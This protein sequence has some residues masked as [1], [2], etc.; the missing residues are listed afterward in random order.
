MKN[1]IGFICVLGAFT[2]PALAAMDVRTP[3]SGN[4]AATPTS[5]AA[6]AP[7]LPRLTAA[8]I[9]D[10]NVAARG[11][12]EAWRHVHSMQMSGLMDL[13]HA[14]KR[15]VPVAMTREQRFERSH[16]KYKDEQKEAG[17]LVQA[18]FLMELERPTKVRV[19]LQFAGQ[20]AVQVYDGEHG[21]KLRP[22]L[23]RKEP[24]P[25]TSDEL[26]AAAQQQELDGPLIDYA[27]KG[28]KI[29]LAGTDE[30]DGHSTYKLKVMLRSG[31]TRYVWIDGTSFLDVKIDGVPRRMDGKLRSVQTYMRDYRSVD[32]LMIPHLIETRVERVTD[33]EKIAIDHV[34][35]NP[36]LSDARFDKPASN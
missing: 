14:R 3:G 1:K 7:E 27:A 36:A 35:L 8:Q 13:G 33:S 11:G 31:D 18:P 15:Q 19:E 10:K 34:S 5:P 12:L 16:G 26:K 21:W 6:R 4:V 23:N 17:K 28:N 24:E 20:T 9:V 30:V 32:G 22:F 25:F 29:E 2:V